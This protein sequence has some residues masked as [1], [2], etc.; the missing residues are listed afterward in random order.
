MNRIPFSVY[1][2]FGY[3]AS[4]FFL[5]VAVDYAFGGG[6]LLRQD[7][8][9]ALSFFWIVVA[10]VSG[11]IVANISG[12]LIEKRLVRDVFGSPEEVLLAEK[13]ARGWRQAFPGFFEPLPRE[14]RERVL[15]RAK[16]KAGIVTPGR[17]LFLHCHAIVKRDQA[18]LERLNTFLNLYGFCRNLSMASTMALLVLVGSVISDLLSHVPIGH[19]KLWWASAAVVAAIGMFYRYLKFFRHYTVEVFTT[20]AEF[21]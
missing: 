10:Y 17:S 15:H 9:P 12:F 20:Y 14:T 19:G 1:D 5:L 16:E 21:D 4:G 11:H 2:V 13:N 7:L 8:R 6:S 18:T 3:L